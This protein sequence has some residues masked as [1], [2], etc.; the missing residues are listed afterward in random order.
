MVGV[1]TFPRSAIRW[2]TLCSVN[3]TSLDQWGCHTHVP[4]CVQVFKFIFVVRRGTSGIG[5]TRGCSGGGGTRAG[6][7]RKEG[8]KGNACLVVRETRPFLLYKDRVNVGW[9]SGVWAVSVPAV[10]GELSGR[11]D[12]CHGK[13][14]QWER[15]LRGCRRVAEGLYGC[16]M[17]NL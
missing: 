9:V 5:G 12:V 4:V 10:L 17:W 1:C 8:R 15:N 7:G 13:T 2:S 3:S 6:T 11:T 14:D 16:A